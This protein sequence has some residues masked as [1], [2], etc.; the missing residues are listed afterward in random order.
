M[1]VCPAYSEAKQAVMSEFE[2]RK[3]YCKGKTETGLFMLKRLRKLWVSEVTQLCPI[4]CDSMDCSLPGFSVHGI[5]QARVLEWVAISFSR[6]SS[7]PRD[8]T[9]VSRI[10][11]RCFTLG[12]WKYFPHKQEM[13]I[14]RKAFLPGRTPRDLAW[15]QYIFHFQY[16]L[17][18]SIELLV[19]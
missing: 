13:G 4:L 9:R 2:Q 3:V 1:F 11:G 8:W 10:A 17:H 16:V 14:L 7:Q 18:I 6:G 19:S 12:G 5:F 15:F